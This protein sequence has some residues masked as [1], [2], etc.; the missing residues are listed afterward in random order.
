MD[1]DEAARDALK[2]ASASSNPESSPS[3]HAH[4]TVSQGRARTLS[5]SVPKK[6]TSNIP[7]KCTNPT[8]VCLNAANSQHLKQGDDKVLATTPEAGT[9][10]VWTDTDERVL[11]SVLDQTVEKRPA[12]TAMASPSPKRRRKPTPNQ[13]PL[14]HHELSPGQNHALAVARLFGQLFGQDTAAAF[15]DSSSKRAGDMETSPEARPEPTTQQRDNSQELNAARK[16]D[17]VEE[18]QRSSRGMPKSTGEE[19]SDIIHVDAGTVVFAKW[20]DGVSLAR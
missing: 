20:H 16:Q 18:E 15:A 13:R 11:A 8:S 5:K 19:D 6:I 17:Q 10:L 4:R 1:R 14:E 12:P 9:R 2:R 3:S 7:R